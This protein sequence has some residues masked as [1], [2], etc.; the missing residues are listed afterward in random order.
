MEYT[1]NLS[2]YDGEYLLSERILSRAK[3]YLARIKLK[4]TR[5][6][7]M[8]ETDVSH[9][10]CVINYINR[11]IIIGGDGNTPVC[12]EDIITIIRGRIGRRFA[13]CEHVAI[14]WEMH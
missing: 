2:N 12:D 14:C 4:A 5:R 10:A 13:T 8:N 6:G 3:R 1:R 11:H 7:D 9:A